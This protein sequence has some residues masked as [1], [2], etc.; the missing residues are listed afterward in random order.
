M[1]VFVVVWL[2]VVVYLLTVS[3]YL[4]DLSSN[5]LMGYVLQ[6]GIDYNE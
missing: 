6:V 3:E 5:C 1:F 4:A 2:F